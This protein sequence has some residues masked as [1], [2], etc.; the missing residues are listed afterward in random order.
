MNKEQIDSLTKLLELK[1]KGV[2]SEDEFRQEKRKLLG[3]QA[4]AIS[5]DDSAFTMMVSS[6]EARE[7]FDKYNNTKG[8]ARKGFINRYIRKRRF[9]TFSVDRRIKRIDKVGESIHGAE[10]IS[11]VAREFRDAGFN[12]DEAPN[13]IKIAQSSMPM[14]DG[15]GVNADVF[16]IITFVVREKSWEIQGRFDVD[17]W[18]KKSDQDIYRF[19]FPIFGCI[20][21]PVHL[22]DGVHGAK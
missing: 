6:P 20:I 8:A 17:V 18:E 1:E 12:V 9:F 10:L 15:V 13:H 7:I 16:G 19:C 11:K 4:A 3:E 5:S 14:A 22:F 21:S 2:L